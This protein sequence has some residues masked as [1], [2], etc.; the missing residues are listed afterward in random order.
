MSCHPQ[1]ATSNFN[2]NP[3]TIITLLCGLIFATT[4]WVQA[5]TFTVL[6]EF[7]GHNDG[8]RPGG[9][10]KDRA[11]NLYGS[12]A[13]G[14]DFSCNGGDGGPPGCGVLF[15]LKKDDTGWVLNP[16]YT[17]PGSLQGYLSNYP[18]GLAIAPNGS[19]YGTNFLG[20]NGL[21]I[22]GDGSIFN[23]T[24][25]PVAPASVLA[26]WTYSVIY[27]F[28]GSSDGA[29]PT[30]TAPLL[31]DQAGNIYGTTAYGDGSTNYGVVY[32]ATRSG[33]SWMV[34]GLYSFLGGSDGYSPIGVVSDDAGNLYGVT[35]LGGNTGC[36]YGDGG[37]CGLI[38]E[39]SHSQSG[40]TKTTLHIFEQ[41][42]DGGNSGA[43]IRDGSGNLYGITTGYG[44]NSN[45]G[46]VW[47]MSPS[48]GGWSFSVIHAFPTETL[49]ASGPFPLTMDAAGNLYGLTTLGGAANVGFLF[50]LTPSNGGWAYTELYDF[51]TMPGR[52]DG[53]YPQGAPQLDA[54]GNI[55]GTTELCG[56]SADVGNVWKFTP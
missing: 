46:T 20:G 12:T 33:S 1:R 32:E 54:A 39:L 31:F 5:Q 14:G 2:T 21:G 22:Y 34:T 11:G 7:T 10:T 15:K 35:G 27:E 36:D 45:G 19:L 44:P 25:S 56:G 3:R 53:C 41:G 29:N 6:H 37:G 42:V 8:A 17:F 13:Y 9:M 51:G 50:E 23:A 30:G 52:S 4:I 43:L 40:W 16:L 18:G 26:P 48:N 24:P 28:S 38:Y 47:E 49:N 55:Y